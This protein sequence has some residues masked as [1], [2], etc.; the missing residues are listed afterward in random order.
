MFDMT[1]DGYKKA[2]D[3]LVSKNKYQDFLDNPISTD[4]Y[5]LV[6]FANKISCNQEDE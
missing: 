1:V 5:S 6:E 3:Y 4:G 2:K